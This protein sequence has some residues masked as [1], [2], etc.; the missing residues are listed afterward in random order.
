MRAN[1]NRKRPAA[2]HRCAW[3]VC[4]S[5]STY[6]NLCWPCGATTS[7]SR[8]SRAPSP[9]STPGASPSVSL[10]DPPTPRDLRTTPRRLSRQAALTKFSELTPTR[11]RYSSNPTSP[12]TPLSE[13]HFNTTS[14]RLSSWNFLES[15][16]GAAL[17]ARLASR[18]RSST[19]F[20]IV[21]FGL[22]K[23]CWATA[24]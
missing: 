6:H 1:S 14:F 12:W 4:W 11:A 5:S 20:S 8:R 9:R 24:T 19:G 17:P 7:V 3:S 13:R 16:S 22:L 2:V 18:P 15:Q 23:W 21:R 10:T